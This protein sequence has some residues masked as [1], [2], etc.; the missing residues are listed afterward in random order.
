MEQ[1]IREAFEDEIVAPG[2]KSVELFLGRT[3][4]PHKGHNAIFK[5]MKNGVFALVK[6]KGTS[7]DKERNPFDQKYQIK[8]IKKMAPGMKIVVV[9]NG[10]V[11]E[12]INELRKKGMEVNAVYAGDDRIKVYKGMIDGLNKKLDDDKKFKVKFKLTPRITSATDVRASIRDNDKKKFETNMPKEIWGE[13]ETMK[14]KM[15]IKE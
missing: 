8:L 4:P 10:F 2:K 13:F 11:P 5:M 14:K 12:I 1:L 9:P 7:Q 15:G 3:N 6:G